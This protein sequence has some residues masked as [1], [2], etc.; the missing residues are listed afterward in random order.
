MADAHSGSISIGE[1]IASTFATIGRNP[2]VILGTTLVVQIISVAM[3]VAMQAIAHQPENIGHPRAVLGPTMLTGLIGLLMLVVVHIVLVRATAAD[4]DGRRADLGECLGG[5]ARF[6]LP[7]IGLYVLMYLGM[8]AGML[9]L[10]VPGVI[11]ALMWSAAGPALI[12]E[13]IGVIA[14]FGRSR[15]LTKGHRWAIFGLWLLVGALFWMVMAVVMLATVGTF[16]LAR[17][18][19]L[20]SAGQLPIAY[21][22]VSVVTGTLLTAVTGVLFARLYF[23]LREA[24]E[25]PGNAELADIFS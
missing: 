25:G 16:S 2:L 11:L 10:I 22:A 1:I 21:H 12:V 19:A 20:S 4:A 24:A 17:L 7:L 14:A 23:A 9:L 8:V 18:G 3:Q 15:A 13:R 5:A 6:I